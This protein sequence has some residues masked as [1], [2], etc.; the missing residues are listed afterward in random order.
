MQGRKGCW[1][2]VTGCWLFRL[3]VA[4]YRLPVISQL[5][6]SVHQ[7]HVCVSTTPD[8]RLQS[9]GLLVFFNYLSVE[10]QQNGPTNPKGAFLGY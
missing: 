7:T 9:L 10:I 3:P 8:S 2:L 1:L 6:S 5:P 4:S